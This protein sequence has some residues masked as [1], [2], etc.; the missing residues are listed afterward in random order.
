MMR[1]PFSWLCNQVP[2]PWIGHKLGGRVIL[3]HVHGHDRLTHDE[4]SYPPTNYLSVLFIVGPLFLLRSVSV[5]SQ[6][7]LGEA[8][9]RFKFGS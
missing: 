2:L 5:L 1:P 9:R 6:R 3:L 7:S 8:S 4:T